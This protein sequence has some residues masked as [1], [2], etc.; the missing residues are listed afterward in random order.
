MTLRLPAVAVALCVTAALTACGGEDKPSTKPSP[1]PVALTAAQAKVLTAAGVL[2]EADMPGYDAAPQ[3]ADPENDALEVK[4]ASCLGIAA[5]TY[6]A[7]DLGKAYTK[8]ELEIDSSADAFTTLDAAKARTAAFKSAKGEACVKQVLT[9]ELASNN[10]TV[11]TFTSELVPVTVPGSDDAF[12]YKLTFSGTSGGQAIEFS[13]F[14][15]AAR[16]G[17][18]EAELSV[19]ASAANSFTQEQTVELLSKAAGRIKAAS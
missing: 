3:K 16:V 6:L 7:R 19:I 5:P 18:V 2:T 10:L 8:G 13:G 17:Q 9:E 15:A 14:E 11:T 4:L 1:T 12:L